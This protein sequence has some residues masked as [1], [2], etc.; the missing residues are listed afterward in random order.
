M[1]LDKYFNSVQSE[2]SVRQSNR[3]TNRSWSTADEIDFL[4]QV[5]IRRSTP[6]WVPELKWI[7]NYLASM[8]LRRWPSNM[9]RNAIEKDAL[10]LM[11]QLKLDMLNEKSARFSPYYA[12][13]TLKQ[14]EGWTL[15]DLR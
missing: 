15:E 5:L 1:D 2:A 3:D 4:H 6:L 9:D 14:S 13:K 8:K 11:T 10:W 12:K 7:Q